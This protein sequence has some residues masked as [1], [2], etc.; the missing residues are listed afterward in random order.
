VSIIVLKK[1]ALQFTIFNNIIF[2]LQTKSD[3]YLK[4]VLRSQFVNISIRTDFEQILLIIL[5]FLF[6]N[7][8]NMK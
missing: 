3:E 5:S 7:V 6:N 2:C 8:F 1:V 4:T